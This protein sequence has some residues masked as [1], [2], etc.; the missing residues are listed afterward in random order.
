MH[1]YA[2]EVA[3][4]DHQAKCERIACVH[5]MWRLRSSST[6]TVHRAPY[7]WGTEVAKPQNGDVEKSGTIPLDFS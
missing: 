4:H 5:K 2:A 3:T 7:T 1:D 6:E